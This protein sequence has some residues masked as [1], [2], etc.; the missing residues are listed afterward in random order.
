M[1]RIVP[2]NSQPNSHLAVTSFLA[3]RNSQHMQQKWISDHVIADIASDMVKLDI[4]ITTVELNR[5]V[6]RYF[7][8]KADLMHL[9][10]SNNYG[11]YKLQNEKRIDGKRKRVTCYFFTTNLNDTPI[12]PNPNTKIHQ[13]RA[14][15]EKT[16]VITRSTTKYVANV[17]DNINLRPSKRKRLSEVKTEVKVHV[18]EAEMRPEVKSEL[19]TDK[20][21]IFSQEIFWESPEAKCWFGR[22]NKSENVEDVMQETIENFKNAYLTCEGWR[23]IISDNDQENMCT[24]HDIH[25][26]RLKAM[27]L[28]IALNTALQHMPQKTWA[29]CCDD[30]VTLV[31]EFYQHLGENSSN[32]ILT[33]NGKT[34]QKWFCT[35]KKNSCSF[36]NPH[37]IRHGK[38]VLPNLLENYPD[39]RTSLIKEMEDNLSNL[40]GEY[41]FSFLVEKGLPNILA[42]R[43]KEL[44]DANFTTSQLLEE[45][46]LTKITLTT[47]YR[48]MHILGFRYEERKKCYYVDNHESISNVTYRRGF[49]SRYF[50]HETRAHRW[51]QLQLEE[52]LKLEEE[53]KISI[54]NG[55]RYNKID[56]QGAKHTFVEFHVD[57]SPAFEDFI[58]NTK[59][60]G[61]ISVRKPP[62]VK[63]LLM[64]GQDECIFKQFSFTKKSWRGSDDKVPLIPKDDGI[65]I[66]ISAFASREFG[67]GFDI[68]MEQMTE[69]NNFRN[70][71][72]YSDKVAATNKLGSAKKPV[73]TKSPFVIHFEYGV[74][75]EGYWNYDSMLI[76]FED[77]IDC[78]KVLYPHYNYMFL[79]DH[80]C[81]HD[82]KRPDGLSVSGMTKGYGGSQVK[83]KT[84]KIVRK[85][86]YLGKYHEQVN[87]LK[88][89]D[90]Q[91]MVFSSED[92]GPFGKSH[93]QRQSSKYDKETGKMKTIKYKMSELIEKL[94]EKGVIAKG[95]R[96]K[97]QELATHNNIPLQ[98]ERPIIEEG[99]VDKPKG[100]LQVLYERGFLDPA[101][102]NSYTLEGRKDEYGHLIPDTS[103][104]VMMNSLID[105]AEEETL[106]QYHGRLLGVVVDRTPKCHPEIAGEGIEYSWAAAKIFYRRLRIEDKRTKTRFL[107][108]VKKST[109]RNTVLTMNR[110]RL[111]SRRARK[112]MLAYRAIDIHNQQGSSKEK[113]SHGL[114]EKVLKAYNTHR[115][116]ATIEYKWIQDVVGT[117]KN[118][119]D[120]D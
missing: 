10:H 85:E 86:G 39:L 120:V 19:E 110:Q 13:T 112:Y 115:T 92:V 66:M 116:T 59:F 101:K 35:W 63:P 84:S 111:F 25:I 16:A 2:S 76:Q 21:N 65:G 96:K 12:L 8:N 97:I 91:S 33:K 80:S 117:M 5:A 114:L 81:G 64:F 93:I 7:K 72:E 68:S 106:L 82:K 89:G 109:H 20:P 42:Q 32:S 18:E 119:I 1:A 55:F 34:I 99:W 74:Q 9:H 6:S 54:K 75:A 88:V 56:S 60:G 38:K 69:I 118:P 100:M 113:M 50:K 67:Y 53:G 108:S 78:L 49:L 103:L 31:K 4:K 41:V 36:H 102:I 26:I 70:G 46:G 29:M 27:Y 83:M 47:I 30:A 11:I 105:F 15:V 3:I 44:D 22:G 107:E 62:D 61:N 104:K 48:W 43:Q 24:L 17:N 87:L 77:C 57:D 98:Y 73:L 79:F 14:S 58:L 95:N 90:T 45:N 71:K 37:F 23:Y 52:A 28:A 51:I 40:T 94:K